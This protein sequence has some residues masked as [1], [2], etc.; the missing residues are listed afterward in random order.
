MGMHDPQLNS[1]VHGRPPVGVNVWP[2][3][4]KEESMDVVCLYWTYTRNGIT[5]YLLQ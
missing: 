4:D 2:G 5:N 3:V 1:P